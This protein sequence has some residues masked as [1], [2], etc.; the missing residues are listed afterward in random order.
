[1]LP[2]LNLRALAPL[3]LALLAG[4]A[5]ADDVQVAVAANFTGP[6]QK[7]AAAFEKE[8]GHK[9]VLS[10]GATG[11]FYAQI[12][13]GAPFEILLSADQ[14]TPEK[15][16]AEG[17]AIADTR[18]TYATGKLVLWSPKPGFIDDKARVL[19]QSDFKHIAI[20]NP[21]T[22]PYGVAAMQ[23]IVL[24]GL[25]DTLEPR[26]VTGENITQAFQF[27]AGGNAELG[28][29]ALSQVLKDGKI[30]GSSWIVPQSLYKP[31][32][33]DAVL[34][35]TAKDKPAARALLKYLTSDPAKAII[36]SF[37]YEL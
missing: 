35:T 9:V 33:Q 32:K 2:R 7:I 5:L 30:E 18:F 24:L 8:S 22:A 29:V 19:S 14:K 36:K 13:N 26:F 21:K 15:L 12:K 17:A 4:H 10:F 16:A 25:R 37:G 6:I 23:A 1:M 28:F 20:A 11:G 27:V 3:L 31:L 34:L